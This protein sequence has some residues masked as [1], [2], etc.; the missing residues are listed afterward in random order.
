MEVLHVLSHCSVATFIRQLQLREYSV[1]YLLHSE[2]NPYFSLVL[3]RESWV[4]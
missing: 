3:S 4:S 1:L 2:Q